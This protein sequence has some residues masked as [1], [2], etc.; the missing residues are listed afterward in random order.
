MARWQR[1]MAPLTPG[2]ANWKKAKQHVA[3]IHE[4]IAESIISPGH[5]NMVK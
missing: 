3:R 2:G 5:P 1:R 4:R